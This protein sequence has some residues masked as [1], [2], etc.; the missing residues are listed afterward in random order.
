MQNIGEFCE[1][2]GANPRNIVIEFFL[3]MRGDVTEVSFAL[4]EI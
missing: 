3:E 4:A 1:I 2:F